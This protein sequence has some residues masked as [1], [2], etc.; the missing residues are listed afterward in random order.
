MAATPT[1]T[2]NG[3]T[4]VGCVKWFNNKDGYGFITLAEGEE[5][6]DIFVHHSS[7]VVEKNQ[8]KYLVQGEYVGFDLE[9]VDGNEKYTH[10]AKSVR[11]VNGGPLMCETRNENSRPTDKQPRGRMVNKVD[12]GKQWMLVQRRPQN[13]SNRDTQKKREE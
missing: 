11:G 5:S 7:I 6:K 13:R 10:Q 9:K 4:K 3:S 12:L 8:Y 2:S 1:F